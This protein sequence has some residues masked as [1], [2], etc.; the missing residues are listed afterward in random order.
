MDRM[1]DRL[2]NRSW[3][4]IMFP[5]AALQ[6]AIHNN[7]YTELQEAPEELK[8]TCKLIERLIE[9]KNEVGKSNAAKRVIGQCIFRPC[10]FIETIPCHELRAWTRLDHAEVHQ[11]Y[12]CDSC[13]AGPIV[14]P[15]F[16]RSC[17]Y[18]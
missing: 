14:G 10:E 18:R 15:R 1:T 2:A 13:D 5:D 17:L 16:I 7:L 6:A 9:C 3:S 12:L 4:H 8:V 11:G